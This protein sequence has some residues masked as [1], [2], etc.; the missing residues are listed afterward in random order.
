MLNRADEACDML[1]KHIENKSFVRIISHHDAD[2]LSAAAVIIN[3]LIEEDIQF[4]VSNVSHLT[5]D[6]VRSLKKDKSDLIIFCDMGSQKISI[7]NTFKQDVIIA[8]HHQLSNIESKDHIVHVNPILFGINGSNFLSGAGSI[9]LVVRNLGKKHLAYLALVGAFG[10]MQGQNGF[11]GINKLILDDAI[12]SGILEVNDGLKIVS[13]SSEP[14]YK[15]LAYTFSPPLPGISGDLHAS[16]EF[17]EKLGISYGLKF[18]DL[19]DEEKDFLIAN[20]IKINEDIWGS[21]YTV[22]KEPPILRDLEE[23]AYILDECGKNKKFGIALSITIGEREKVLD[24]AYDLHTKYRENIVKGLE[25]INKVGATQLDYIQYVYTEDDFLKS[26]LGAIVGIALSCKIVDDSKPILGLS[27]YH[28]DIK[29]TART[30][31]YMVEKGVNL[32]KVLHD[33]ASNYN[34]SGGG[35]DIAAGAMIPFE[36]KDDFLHLADQMVDYQLN[37]GDDYAS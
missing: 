9:Y 37:P 31:R 14:L 18:D 7:L 2:G 15:S 26:I 21:C 11:E 34:A 20:L 1:K 24:V 32:S 4:H 33:V 19:E 25:W 27:K 5:D 13:K 16:R 36:V 35:H 28:K 17:L 8:D 10:D 30:V 3:T 6:F 23:Y 12:E 29:V 22:A